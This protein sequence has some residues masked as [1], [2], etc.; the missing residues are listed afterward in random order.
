M[1]YHHAELIDLDLFCEIMDESVIIETVSDRELHLQFLKHPVRGFLTGIQA[2]SA[3]LLVRGGYNDLRERVFR[4]S[5]DTLP[6]T[7]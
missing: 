4:V 1:Q 6:E 5:D 3:V 2:G 7:P